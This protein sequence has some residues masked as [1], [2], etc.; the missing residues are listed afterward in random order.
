MKKYVISQRQSGKTT[1]IINS[2]QEGDAIVTFN[3]IE[4]SRIYNL[5][6]EAGKDIP[7]YSTSAFDQFSTKKCNISAKTLFIDEFEHC[8][9]DEGFIS[10]ISRLHSESTIENICAYGT[11]KTTVD[12]IIIKMLKSVG[13]NVDSLEDYLTEEAYNKAVTADRE[14]YFIFDKINVITNTEYNI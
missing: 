5:L 2:V 13:G 14:K 10:E 12:P 3:L 1:S 9:M 6:L 7:V 4:R 11:T 8:A